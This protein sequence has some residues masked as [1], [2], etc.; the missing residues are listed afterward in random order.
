MGTVIGVGDEAGWLDAQG[1]LPGINRVLLVDALGAVFGGIASSSSVTSYIESAAGVAEGARTGLASVV[2]GILF[3]LAMLL[4][5]LVAIVPAEATAPA[6]IVVGFYMAAVI[7]EMDFISV[8][9]GLP[10]LLTM[11]VMPFTFSI[12]NGIGAGFVMYSFLKLAAGKAHEVHWMMWVVSAA[13]VLYFSLA[14]LK[15]WFGI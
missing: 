9:D 15:S 14:V 2:T 7:R 4:A 12:T 3:L 10:A 11:A 5:P 8:E 13:F 6:L 1:R